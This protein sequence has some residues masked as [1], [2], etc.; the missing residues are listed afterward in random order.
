M[1]KKELLDRLIR[2]NP[3]W[4]EWQQLIDKVRS[5]PLRYSEFEHL[6]GYMTDGV[7]ATFAA[8]PPDLV[9]PNW[10]PAFVRA[11]YGMKADHA[12]IAGGYADSF[13][14]LS[15]ETG[16]VFAN[17]GRDED[18]GFP[19]ITP[20]LNTFA[21]QANSSGA[22]FHINTVLEV[23]YPDVNTKSLRVLD[24]LETFTLKNIEQFLA[25]RTWFHAY[26][27]LDANLLD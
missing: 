19:L 6:G 24:S 27:D 5:V 13:C 7:K 23:L 16:S 15:T 14:G 26:K 12:E 17:G 20:P 2:A 25:G 11:L 21:F 10:M 8:L 3:G 1:K 22:L 4:P 18:M 9:W